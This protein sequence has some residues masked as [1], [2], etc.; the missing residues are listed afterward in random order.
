M[1]W[2]IVAVSLAVGLMV[3]FAFNIWHVWKVRLLRG[4]LVPASGRIAQAGIL[5]RHAA[6]LTPRLVVLFGAM[7]FV[8]AAMSALNGLTNSWDL[9]AASGTVLFAVCTGYWTVMYT[10]RRRFFA[11]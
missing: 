10:M 4:G 11:D 2:K 9:N 7:S 5:K 1:S 8:L 3:G 6:M